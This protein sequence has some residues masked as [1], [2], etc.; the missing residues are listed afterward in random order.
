[1]V[2][3]APLCIVSSTGVSVLPG[4]YTSMAKSAMSGTVKGTGSLYTAACA[5]IAT[6]GL[7]LKVSGRPDAVWIDASLSRSAMCAAPIVSGAVPYTLLSTTRTIGPPML[8][9]TI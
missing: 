8:R 1:M 7:P 9:C 5:G 2:W 3:N 6:V 4:R